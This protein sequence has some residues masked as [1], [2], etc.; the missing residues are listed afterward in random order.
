[1]ERAAFD[2]FLADVGLASVFDAASSQGAGKITLHNTA[3]F[4]INAEVEAIKKSRAWRLRSY[5]EYRERFGLQ[6]L[7]SFDELTDDRKLLME[8]NTLYGHVDRVELLVGLLAESDEDTVL[9]RLMTLMVGVD[10]YSQALTNPL[11]ADTV[12]NEDTFTKIGLESIANTS[13]LAD[14]VH[15]NKVAANA[16][17]AFAGEDPPGSYGCPLVGPRGACSTSPSSAGGWNSFGSVSANT[18]RQ[19]LRQIYLARRSS[20]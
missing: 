18:E 17:V 12:Y 9:G 11:L 1:M 7:T 4:L 8:L 14:I 10:A 6:K 20:H 19:L 5:N 13:S 16:K 3:P 2:E 15:R